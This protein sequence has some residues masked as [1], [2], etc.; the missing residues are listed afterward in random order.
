MFILPA[1]LSGRTYEKMISSPQDTRVLWVVSP[2][3]PEIFSEYI[4]S[5]E[6]INY[7]G[8]NRARPVNSI[9][10]YFCS[11]RGHPVS[12]SVLGIF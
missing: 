3:L 9:A 2:F 6:A 4:S 1:L 8:W 12:V 5:P 7:T 10:T 11:S